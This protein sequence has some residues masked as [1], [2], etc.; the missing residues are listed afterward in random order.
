MDGISNGKLELIDSHDLLSANMANYGPY[1][2]IVENHDMEINTR[3]INDTNIDD[4]INYVF[5]VFHDGIN[6]DEIQSSMVHVT[7]IDKP[8]GAVKYTL[9]D[10]LIQ[11]IFW[12]LPASIHEAITTETVFWNRRITTGYICDYV[13]RIFIKKYIDRIKR[14]NIQMN[15]ELLINMN[16][17]INETFEM[18][19]RFTAFQMYLNSTLCLEDTLDF[20]NKYPDFNDSMHLRLDGTPLSEVNKLGMDAADLQIKYI[21]APESDHCLKVFFQS[22]ECLA[23]KQYKEVQAHVGPKPNGE[24]GIQPAQIDASYLNGGLNNPEAYVIDAAASR[25]AQIQ[26][27]ENVGKSGDFARILELNSMDTMLYPDSRYK[28]DTKHT[29]TRYIKDQATLSKYDG[30]YYRFHK[31]YSSAG[32]NDQDKV[33]D[34][35]KDTWLIGK[36]IE[37]YSPM[38]CASRS[39]SEGICYRCYGDLAYT[40]FN[41]NVGVIATEIVSSKYTQRQLSA[42][43]ILEAKVRELQWNNPVDSVF[44]I[45]FNTITC[46]NTEQ[47]PEY[48][49]RY[50]NAVLI[51]NIADFDYEDENDDL[52]FNAFVTSFAVRE[53]GVTTEYHTD[54]NDMIYLAYELNE[55]IASKMKSSRYRNLTDEDIDIE[56]PFSEL[57]ELDELFMFHIGNDE[58]SKTIL[59]AKALI[60]SARITCVLNKDEILEQFCD[61][62]IAGGFDTSSVHY[63]IILANQM[64][65]ADDELEYPDW[66]KVNI[67][68]QIPTLDKSLKHNPSVTASLQ[69]QKLAQMI[70]KPIM[71]IK[72]RKSINDLYFMV[73]PQP[74]IHEAGLVADS[75]E[76]NIKSDAD[77]NMCE[78]VRFNKDLIGKGE[79]KR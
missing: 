12:K 58:L 30:R 20:M 75:R 52:E 31:I 55:I 24:G 70:W 50:A 8:D 51:I 13:N 74:Y 42:K 26:S 14:E 57:I 66:T 63:E 44:E 32:S 71:Y 53:N 48:I 47:Y 1:S 69:Y 10:Y 21:T 2:C 46:Y 6:L 33:I 54:Q 76:V 61:T 60:N 19:K 73:Q 9:E 78:A 11:L 56:I 28:C 68:Y 3:N 15:T 40:N 23:K 72:H 35:Q 62:N 41:I 43:H 7:F 5:N 64:R 25:V 16:I 67:K 27:H 38:T 37:L 34:A 18:F 49:E 22:G 65:D 77:R 39:R 79:I 59:A 36:T 29:I 17:N 4:H 45:N